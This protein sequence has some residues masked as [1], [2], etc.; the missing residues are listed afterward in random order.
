MTEATALRDM[1]RTGTPDHRVLEG[2]F[3]CPVDLITHVLDA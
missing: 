3:Q 1:A 2:F